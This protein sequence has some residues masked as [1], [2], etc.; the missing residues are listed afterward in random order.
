MNVEK[1]FEQQKG[2]TVDAA[3][4]ANVRYTAIDMC[5]FA[6]LYHNNEMNKQNN[7]FNCNICKDTKVNDNGDYCA[8]CKII[9]IEELD[10]SIRCI[11]LLKQ[12]NIKYLNQLSSYSKEDLY[13][14][15]NFGK[16]SIKEVEETMNKYGLSLKSDVIHF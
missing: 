15:K 5:K 8:D 4:N 7:L 14:I 2:I 6:Q 12:L 1:F 9:P 10:I 3:R 13:K 16:R 11:T